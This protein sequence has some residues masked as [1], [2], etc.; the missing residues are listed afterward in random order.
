M[1]PRFTNLGG[2][3]CL[4]IFLLL[5]I[6]FVFVLRDLLRSGTRIRALVALLLWLPL[7][8]LFLMINQWEGPLYAAAKGN[9]PV[10]E[11]RGLAGLCGVDLYGPEQ[12]SAEWY[13]DNIGLIWSVDHTLRFPFEAQ[14][15]YGEIPSGFQQTTPAFNVTPPP[16]D[17]NV[18]YK[19]VLNR[20]MGGPQYLS[21]RGDFISE[22]TPNSNAC[23]GELKI[24]ER[25]NSAFVRVDCKTR[26]PLPMS[27]RAAERLKE[28][29]EGRIPFY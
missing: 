1:F 12:D 19:L 10:F 4:V 21:L 14:F 7:L 28:Y 15:H 8:F 13:G 3:L 18:T 23:W 25:Q 11:A 16:L 29:R 2:Y 27:K 9:P 5:A 6:D 17:P 24:P 22:Y 20:C 26:Q